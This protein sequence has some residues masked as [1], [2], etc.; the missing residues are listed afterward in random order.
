[1]ID[2]NGNPIIIIPT[3]KVKGISVRTIIQLVNNIIDGTIIYQLQSNI[4]NI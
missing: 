1:M 2:I 3:L 4:I